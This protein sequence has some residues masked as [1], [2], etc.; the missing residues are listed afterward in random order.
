MTLTLSAEANSTIALTM[1]VPSL[2]PSMRTKERSIFSLSMM[3]R[4]R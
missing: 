1:A 4:F 2:L 3:W